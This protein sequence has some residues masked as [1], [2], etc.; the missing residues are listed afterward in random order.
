MRY[1]RVGCM[2][3]ALVLIAAVCIILVVSWVVFAAALVLIQIAKWGLSCFSPRR[4]PP[5]STQE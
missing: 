3:V 5:D 2:S 1:E 4:R